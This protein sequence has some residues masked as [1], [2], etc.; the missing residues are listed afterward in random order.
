MFCF[1]HNRIHSSFSIITGGNYPIRSLGR[2]VALLCY[3]LMYG[4]FV[5]ADM[6]EMSDGRQF[7]GSILAQDSKTVKIDTVIASIRV[8]HG[9]RSLSYL[10]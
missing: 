3:A 10:T 1:K 7:E 5:D 9:L 4:P 6:V 2:F 8:N